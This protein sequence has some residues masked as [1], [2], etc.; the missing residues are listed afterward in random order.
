MQVL[1]PDDAA[2]LEGFHRLEKLL[3]ELTTF[4]LPVL[5]PEQMWT[6]EAAYEGWWRISQQL[7]S[8]ETRPHPRAR[9]PDR[10]A[11]D[12]SIEQG[13]RPHI[14]EIDPFD[15]AAMELLHGML[16]HSEHEGSSLFA[17]DLRGTVESCE[18][19]VDDFKRLLA[20]L[21]V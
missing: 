3:H 11:E 1:I 2:F 12:A 13:R 7:P 10:D 8:A 5:S 14:V 21:R 19:L 15:L 20:A 16:A 9:R 17:E 4:Y 6:A 18:R